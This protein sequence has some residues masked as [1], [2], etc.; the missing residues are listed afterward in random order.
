VVSRIKPTR[1]LATPFPAFNFL[2]R[3]TG[4]SLLP[5]ELFID[6]TSGIIRKADHAVV[7][8]LFGAAGEFL[9]R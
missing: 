9:E 1:L 7:T 8:S 5:H 3:S 2:P 4:A 6:I